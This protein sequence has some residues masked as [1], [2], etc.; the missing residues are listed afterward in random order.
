MF[1]AVNTLDN[2]YIVILDPQWLGAIRELRR[3][4]AQDLL[5]CQQCRQPVR[6]RAGHVRRWHF[7]HKHLANCPYGNESPELLRTRAALYEWLM[8]KY[9]ERVTIEKRVESEHILR[10]VDC[11]VETEA[12]IISY[13]IIDVA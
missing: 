5:V 11:W 4:D 10:P 12:G 13:W 3:L 1:K 7:A 8:S 6:V 2:N 9:P